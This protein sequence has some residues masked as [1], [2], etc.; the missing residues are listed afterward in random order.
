MHHPPPPSL[1]SPPQFAAL[2]GLP[3][4]GLDLLGNLRNP[5]AAQGHP[6]GDVLV[7]KLSHLSERDVMYAL[8]HTMRM[9]NA[10]GPLKGLAPDGTRPAAPAGPSDDTDGGDGSAE[11]R[12]GGGGWVVAPGGS[13]GRR[14]PG[15]GQL[16]IAERPK[17][18]ESPYASYARASRRAAQSPSLGATDRAALWDTINAATLRRPRSASRGSRSAPP[19]FG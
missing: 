3:R 9:L 17:R 6:A 8:K 13:T 11:G 1:P 10:A 7:G 12:A 4:Y 19:R 15:R 16:A 18:G 14:A 2:A 5:P